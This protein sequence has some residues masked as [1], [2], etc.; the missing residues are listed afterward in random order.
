MF[1]R[2]PRRKKNEQRRK[3]KKK[4]EK[5]WLCAKCIATL[6]IFLIS[7]AHGYIHFFI[8]IFFINGN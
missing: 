2:T 6:S 5:Y 4:K 3:M 1:E 7:Y 8:A